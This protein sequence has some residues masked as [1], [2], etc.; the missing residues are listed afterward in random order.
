MME[1][2]QQLLTPTEAAQIL[3]ISNQTVRKLISL[4]KLVA[5]KVGHR[6]IR[7]DRDSL[8]NYLESRTINR[9]DFGTNPQT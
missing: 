4:G 5:Y 6:T 7:I 3:K 1:I 9:G 8:N 2:T